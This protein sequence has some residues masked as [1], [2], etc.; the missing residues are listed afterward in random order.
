VDNEGE[1]DID[2]ALTE[3]NHVLKNI[4]IHFRDP[5]SDLDLFRRPVAVLTGQINLFLMKECEQFGMSG[6]IYKGI[7]A[8]SKTNKTRFDNIMAAGNFKFE[9]RA[10]Y[11]TRQLLFTISD[12]GERKAS[13]IPE[14]WL[15]IPAAEELYGNGLY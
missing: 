12:G 5:E 6:A 11:K 9:G 10:E 4:D 13:H 15:K 2:E 14:S 7:M 8:C 1:L 3:F